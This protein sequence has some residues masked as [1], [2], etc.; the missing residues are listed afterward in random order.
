[1]PDLKEARKR[2]VDNLQRLYTVV[3]TLAITENLKRLLFTYPDGQTKIGYQ[4]WLMF[5]S[6]IVTV[7][8]FYHGANRY[9]DATYV[10]EERKAKNAALM[11]DFLCLLIQ[12]LLFF[13]VAMSSYDEKRF[14]TILSILLVWDIVWVV[15]T[16]LTA[17]D[18]EDKM[19]GYTNWA[20]INFIA[21]C[22]LMI[23]VWSNALHWQFW[24][25]TLA[26]SIACSFVIVSRTVFDY[27]RVWHFYYPGDSSSKTE[28]N[29]PAPAPAPIPTK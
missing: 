22:A 2:S 24:S 17:A 19:K 12:G 5:V 6:L 9:L 20:M 16:N 28:G 25:S 15:S 7:I 8:P 10:T 14:Y 18:K 26:T 13:V 3:I 29:I 23:F 11:V 4:E 21:T 27:F 1:M